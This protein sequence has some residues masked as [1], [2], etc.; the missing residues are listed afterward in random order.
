MDSNEKNGHTNGHP[1]VKSGVG[2]DA[3]GSDAMGFRGESQRTESGLT[4]IE[5]SRLIRRALDGGWASKPKRWNLDATPADIQKKLD[6]GDELSLRDRM[7][8]AT[9]NGSVSA[10]PRVAGIAVRNGLTMEAQNQADEL[11]QMPDLHLNI[12]KMAEDEKKGHLSAI[13][14]QA[15]ARRAQSNGEQ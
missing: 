8:L 3:I 13:L 5:E 7:L 1:E 9:M 6:A 11:K 14:E 15:K 12:H 2:G 4:G 10:D